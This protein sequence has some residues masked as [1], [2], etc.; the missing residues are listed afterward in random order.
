LSSNLLFHFLSVWA[1]TEKSNCIFMISARFWTKSYTHLQKSRSVWTSGEVPAVTWK[2]PARGRRRSLLLW[3]PSFL[4]T[5]HDLVALDCLHP[6]HQ[7]NP[8]AQNLKS[9]RA[10]QSRTTLDVFY[11][12]LS[13]FLF[14]WAFQPKIAFCTLTVYYAWIIWTPPDYDFKWFSAYFQKH[15]CEL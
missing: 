4:A 11:F 1:S 12:W 8:A 10:P 3:L 15:F 9:Y 6:G 2:W 7:I 14:D 13:L 5:W